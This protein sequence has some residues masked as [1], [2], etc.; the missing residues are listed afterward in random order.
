MN[1]LQIIDGTK[2]ASFDGLFLEV[3]GVNASN[4]Q[5]IALN[6]IKN[7]GVAAAGEEWMFLIK[8]LNGGFSLMISAEK[9]KEW[10]TLT[11]VIQ[12]AQRHLK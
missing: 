5:R 12:E 7:V 10:E 9:K 1:P 2:A 6:R 3:S 8:T 4:T 11:E